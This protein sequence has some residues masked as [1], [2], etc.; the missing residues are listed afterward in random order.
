[1]T[2]ALR[3]DPKALRAV[4][5]ARRK[6]VVKEMEAAQSRGDELYLNDLSAALVE[7]DS[8]L[9]RLYAVGDGPLP[10]ANVSADLYD[11]DKKSEAPAE[12]DEGDDEAM[13]LEG[14]EDEGEEEEE[15]GSLPQ[16]GPGIGLG[17]GQR[18][19]EESFEDEDENPVKMTNKLRKQMGD[20][21]A[22]FLDDY[23]LA[24]YEKVDEFFD[25]LTDKALDLGEV[26]DADGSND[27]IEML[28]D[29]VGKRGVAR[30]LPV[31]E[32]WRATLIKK[33]MKDVNERFAPVEPDQPLEDEQMSGLLGLD[34]A[35]AESMEDAEAV[36]EALEAD[37]VSEPLTDDE[38]AE[39]PAEGVTAAV[40]KARLGPV[41][42]GPVS[43][44]VNKLTAGAN[45]TGER[46]SDFR[47]SGVST[48]RLE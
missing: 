1:M 36:D 21:A 39:E 25:N 37:D 32:D 26:D 41:A 16:A 31:F 44:T 35:G 17:F 13:S 3:N 33:I 18:P 24:I 5:T 46:A 10:S 4:L 34:E 45:G 9:D 40:Q 15:D 22:D 6:D 47:P 38:E 11:D 29:E 23:A 19:E 27:L 43:F 8:A 14:I 2:N 28:R 12:P 30:I 48:P 42:R 20:S 7:I